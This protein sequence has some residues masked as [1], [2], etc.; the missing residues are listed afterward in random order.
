M[1]HISN[2][3]VHCKTRSGIVNFH[4]WVYCVDCV[5][6]WSSHFQ[7]TSLQMIGLKTVVQQSKL[8]LDFNMASL[9]T[10]NDLFG[11]K[12]FQTISTI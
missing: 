11:S 9:I 3:E 1:N 7:H 2:V 5:Y 12:Y 10:S 6:C 8:L 4:K